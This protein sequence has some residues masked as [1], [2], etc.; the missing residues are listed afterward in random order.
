M[1]E[2]PQEAAIF[3][4]PTRERARRALLSLIEGQELG[5]T[6][7]KKAITVTKMRAAGSKDTNATT[8]MLRLWR[9]GVLSVGDSWD[10][11]PA[12]VAPV[13]VARVPVSGGDDLE[14]LVRAAQ[15]HDDLLGAGKAVALR[16]LAGGMDPDVAAQLKH[17]LTEM[18]QSVKGRALEPKDAVEAIL[19]VTEESAPLVEAFEGI[20]DDERRDAVLAYVL[21]QAEQDKAARPTLDTGG[22]EEGA[23]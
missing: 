6:G 1:V 3:K 12:P 18:R 2:M 10:D 19:P 20:V 14:D 22:A 15:T 4:G 17:L 16:M 5:A 13:P 23:A 11:P 8:T 7:D 21:D 9:T